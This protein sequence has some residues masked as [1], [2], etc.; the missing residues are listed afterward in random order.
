[1]KERL[2]NAGI[3]LVVTVVVCGVGWLVS[4]GLY[5]VGLWPLGAAVRVG[6]WGFAAFGLFWM[7][8][9]L[10]ES[11]ESRMQKEIERMR[12]SGKL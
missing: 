3:L 12:R 4:I 5:N 7:I 2:V 1:M 11:P 9:H 6:V 8:R 10:V